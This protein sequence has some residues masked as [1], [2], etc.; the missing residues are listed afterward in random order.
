MRPRRAGCF[1]A[2]AFKL[3]CNARMSAHV[4]ALRFPLCFAIGFDAHADAPPETCPPPGGWGV[5]SFATTV[6][7]RF[8]STFLSLSLRCLRLRRDPHRTI[9]TVCSCVIAD[10]ACAS[11]RG[12][13]RRAC[14]RTLGMNARY[15][16]GSSSSSQSVLIA[17]RVAARV[18]GTTVTE[19]SLSAALFLGPWRCVA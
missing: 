2:L 12:K 13:E 15:T 16:S 7:L 4:M 8:S 19:F 10:V 5:L 3:S 6:C 18:A 11:V 1:A 17:L 14:V 9:G